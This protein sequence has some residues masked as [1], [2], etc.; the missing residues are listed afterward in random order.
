MEQYPKRKYPRASWWRYDSGIYFVT[1][2]TKLHK[3][4]FGR[5]EY[6]KMNS[7]PL[8]I[9]LSECINNIKLHYNNVD[10]PHFVVMP[11]HVHLIVVIDGLLPYS[12]IRVS[13]MQVNVQQRV[14]DVSSVR[15]RIE[16]DGVRER[17]SVVIGGVKAAVTRYANQ[18][19]INFAWQRGFHD[20]I[21]QS[22]DECNRI[23]QYIINNPVT[24]HL[25]CF[26]G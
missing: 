15:K 11:N 21:I 1:I 19:Q 22:W 20:H 4:Y 24:W 6:G 3:H 13:C 2:C 16:K 14:S 25:D 26:Y 12:G 18:Q 10:I 7:Y 9:F 8:G 23:A 17:L 5:I